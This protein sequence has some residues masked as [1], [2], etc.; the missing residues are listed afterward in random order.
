MT[1]RSFIAACA[2]SIVIGLALLASMHEPY[3]LHDVIAGF[4]LAVT[5]GLLAAVINHLTVGK[6]HRTF[7]IWNVGGHGC[8]AGLLLIAIMLSP[9]LGVTD[10]TVLAVVTFSGYFTFLAFEIAALNRRPNT[11]VRTS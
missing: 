11:T 3:A 10:M 4:A 9:F 7:M 8:R 6:D 5:N 2:L 1:L